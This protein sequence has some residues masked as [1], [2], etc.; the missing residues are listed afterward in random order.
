MDVGVGRFLAPDPIRI[1]DAATGQVNSIILGDP[2][3]LNVYGYGLNNP[4]RY[5]D[6]DGLSADDDLDQDGKP[7]IG[8][9]VDPDGDGHPGFNPI[10]GGVAENTVIFPPPVLR[11]ASKGG[12]NKNSLNYVGET[13]VYRIKGAE[14][15]YKIGDSAQGTRVRDDASI[16][17]E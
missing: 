10:I 6:Q 12:V 1:V 17:A 16:R 2:Q 7:D 5:V 4:Y 13:H 9:E 15:T 14:G 11:F 3:R 8:P